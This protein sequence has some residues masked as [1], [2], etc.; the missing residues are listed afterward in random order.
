MPSQFSILISSPEPR[1]SF[2]AL[3]TQY[4]SPMPKISAGILVYRSTAEGIEVLLAH[5]GGP[6]WAKKDLGA[7][8][9]P[10]GEVNEGESLLAAAHREFHEEMGRPIDGPAHALGELKQ[11][12]GKIVHAWAVES[13]FDVALLHSNSFEMEWPPHSGKM[14]S[15]PEI[16]RAEWFD[17]VEGRRRILP[18]QQEFLDRLVAVAAQRES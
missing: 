12:S 15:F 8:T 18:G 1:F 6:F 3:G 5:P 17:L 4:H 7:W 14:S 11:R 10:K 13:D 2:L 16:D 9:I